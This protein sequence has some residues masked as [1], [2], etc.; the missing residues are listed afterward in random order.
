MSDADENTVI[1]NP[2]QQPLLDNHDGREREHHGSLQFRRSKRCVCSVVGVV[3][4]A[5]LWIWLLFWL[6]SG[7]T[8]APPS[9]VDLGKFKPN[10]T[11]V[12]E[13]GGRIILVGDIHGMLSPL[14]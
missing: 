2:E 7:G 10:A 6:L 12:D 5:F 9:H 14:E 1:V 8:T 13:K 11:Y 4:A 3:V